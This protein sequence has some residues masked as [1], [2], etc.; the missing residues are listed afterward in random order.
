MPIVRQEKLIGALYL[1]NNLAAGA[2]TPERCA[3]LEMLSS[4]AAISLEIARLYSA[5]QHSQINLQDQTRILRSI[6]DSM[7]DG[8]AVA[9]EQGKFLLFNPRAEEIFGRGATD[10]T[11]QW[12]QQ[13]GLYLPDQ[14]TP[15][16][17]AELPLV[18]AVGGESVDNVEIFMRNSARPA[19]G[20]LSV[21]ARPL[22]D[23]TGVTRG[24][25]AVFSEVTARKRAEEE[26]R[27]LNRELE[28]RVEQRT[29]QLEMAL[30]KQALLRKEMHHRVK[31]NLQVISSL[32][33]LQS[34]QVTDATMREILRESQL[35]A[36][37]I[38]LIHEKLYQSDDVSE[39]DFADYVRGL[40][41]NLFEAY[42][43]S[44]QKI[45]LTVRAQAVRLDLDTAIP[46]GLI[47]TEL[48]SNALKYA[49][50]DG[51][52]GEITIALKPVGNKRLRLTI[53]DNG[54][55]LPGDF[56]IENAETLGLTL[57][58][59]LTRQLN[60]TLEYRTEHG[61]V[62]TIIFAESDFSK[63]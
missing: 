6:L 58:R 49:F 54:I 4:Q 31:N 2:F 61:T 62:V 57:V 33:F 20:W 46:C 30:K 55:G 42:R 3:V 44:R 56:D 22:T 7:G 45:A 26:V 18:K 47:I 17:I 32:L 63:S 51:R 21:T 52:T 8:V 12:T 38:A 60:G 11:E 15:F 24:G 48:L 36:R 16:P 29:A 39:I 28:R 35:R 9:N 5:L 13:Y 14:K 19:G 50:T 43:V 23:K 10:G 25:V 53:R 37:S 40:A 27:Q 1:E 59:D 41:S 34:L